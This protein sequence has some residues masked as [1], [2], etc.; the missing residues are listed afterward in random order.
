MADL[1]QNL[2][3]AFHDWDDLRVQAAEE[4]GRRLPKQPSQMAFALEQSWHGAQWK[5][6]RW[7][8]IQALVQ[9]KGIASDDL[10]RLACDLAGVP[11]EL[12]SGSFGVPSVKDAAGLALFAEKEIGRLRQRQETVLA[13]RDVEWREAAL[14][15]TP[16]EEPPETRKLRLY[17]ALIRREIRQLEGKL[18]AACLAARPAAAAAAGAGGAAA[19]PGRTSRSERMNVSEEAIRYQNARAAAAEWARMNRAAARFG[20]DDDA[21]PSEQPPPPPPPRPT[22]TATAEPPAGTVSTPEQ[23]TAP[24]AAQGPGG[25][26]PPPFQKPPER[27]PASASEQPDPNASSALFTVDIEKLTRRRAREVRKLKRQKAREGKSWPPEAQ[28]SA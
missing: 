10:H 2:H 15:A 22:P 24:A 26:G 8:G 7:E 3:T 21:G 19:K 17:D 12:R 18:D 4:L 13:P 5:I 23:G 28:A 11:L 27:A 1:E 16:M 20:P 14:E 25:D 9:E 6:Q